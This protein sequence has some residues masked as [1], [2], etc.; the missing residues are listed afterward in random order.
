[1]V[2][3]AFESVDLV[4]VTGNAA[5]GRLP[6]SGSESAWR[7]HRVERAQIVPLII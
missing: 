1:M 6:H 2:G 7:G 4:A 5:M 3:M